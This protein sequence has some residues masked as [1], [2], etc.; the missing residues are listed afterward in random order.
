[1]KLETQVIH[2][3]QAPDPTTANKEQLQAYEKHRQVIAQL[4]GI[5]VKLEVIKN[6]DEA[7]ARL[8]RAANDVDIA[9]AI[10]KRLG[11]WRIIV[12]ARSGQPVQPRHVQ[13]SKSDPRGNEQRATADFASVRQFQH[14]ART[15]DANASDLLRRQNFH[16]KALGL[17]HGAAS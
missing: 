8:D 17:H 16:S 11:H 1:M 9:V 14:P 12:H 7:A 6:L 10:R 2:A 5:L 3:G 13:F 15:F 4:R